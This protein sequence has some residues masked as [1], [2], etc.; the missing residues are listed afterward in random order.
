MSTINIY[1]M[2]KDEVVICLLSQYS[3]MLRD[4]IKYF[5]MITPEV[6]T[7][8]QYKSMAIE[9]IY[10]ECVKHFNYGD[11]VKS[12]HDALSRVYKNEYAHIKEEI[13]KEENRIE[14]LKEECTRKGL[15]FETENRKQL[16][17]R[18]TKGRRSCISCIIVTLIFLILS[19]VGFIFDILIM[20]VFLLIALFLPLCYFWKMIIS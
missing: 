4:Y 20:K 1:T 6:C 8:Q 3:Y 9:L 17:R 10:S 19:V 12:A 18:A 5:E 7:K 15:D 16:T 13:E 11:Y 2:N 14:K